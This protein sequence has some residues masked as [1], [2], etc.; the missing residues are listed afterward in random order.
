MK[1]EH[2]CSGNYL[3]QPERDADYF[4]FNEAGAF[5]LRK[6]RAPGVADMSLPYPSMKPEHFCSGNGGAGNRGRRL[7]SPSM[8]PEH[9]C[10]G[11]RCKRLMARSTRSLQ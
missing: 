5:L 2:F 8:K 9:F 3:S 10:S 7:L 11:N 1:P 4:S 6:R